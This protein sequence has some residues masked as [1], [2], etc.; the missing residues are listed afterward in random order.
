MDKLQTLTEVHSQIYWH[1]AEQVYTL[2]NNNL[3]KF[4][5]GEDDATWANFCFNEL[6]MP[7]S[8]ANQKAHAYEFFISKH[9]FTPKELADYDSYE[10]SYIARTKNDGRSTKE[11]IKGYM[12]DSRNMARKDFID[13]LPYIK[14]TPKQT[15]FSEDIQCSNPDCLSHNLTRS[16][17]RKVVGGWNVQYQCKDCGRYTTKKKLV[18]LLA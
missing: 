6:K 15:A 8:S 3:W 1:R 7:L 13:M 2:K 4:V 10:L 18:K 17:N 14:L 9:G 11:S 12:E 16:K 5:Y